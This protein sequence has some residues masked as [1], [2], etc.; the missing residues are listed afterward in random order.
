MIRRITNSIVLDGELDSCDMTFVDLERIQQSFL[1]TL[2]SMYHHRVDY[3][4]FDFTRPKG[5][6]EPPRGATRADG[7]AAEIADR[8][9]ARGS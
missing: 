9:V 1:R 7:K 6:S 5:E 8:K 2:V 3:P 4:G